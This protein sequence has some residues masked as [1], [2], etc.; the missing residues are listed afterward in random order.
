MC[1]LSMP[2]A[3]PLPPPPPPSI[4][5]LACCR[6]HSHAIS[7]PFYGRNRSFRGRLFLLLFLHSPLSPGYH[8]RRTYTSRVVSVNGGSNPTSRSFQ[9]CHLW[10]PLLF[11][12]RRDCALVASTQRLMLPARFEGPHLP[13]VGPTYG[14]WPLEGC[15]GA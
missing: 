7:N 5:V 4:A 15:P 8:L 1:P 9:I 3:L 13:D 6:T 14:F 10:G 11:S 2:F 12:E